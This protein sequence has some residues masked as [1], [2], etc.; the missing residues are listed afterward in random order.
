MLMLRYACE[1]YLTCEVPRGGFPTATPLQ[2]ACLL[3]ESDFSNRYTNAGVADTKS[4]SNPHE[5][6][7]VADENPS[8]PGTETIAGSIGPLPNCPKCGS[9][10]LH[11]EDDGSRT[12]ETCGAAS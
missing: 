2:P 8:R 5:Y 4:G 12:C 9:F 11:R 6:C 10:A 3:I 7:D 1:R